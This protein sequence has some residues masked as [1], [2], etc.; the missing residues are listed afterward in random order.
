VK[1]DRERAIRGGD[2]FSDALDVDDDAA[3]D[4]EEGGGVELGGEVLER[5]ADEVGFGAAMLP[6]C[7]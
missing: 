7:V 6:P 3:V 1:N 4:A 2:E 5:V